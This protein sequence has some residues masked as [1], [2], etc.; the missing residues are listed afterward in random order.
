MNLRTITV[1]APVQVPP[2]GQKG[3]FLHP[4]HNG[5]TFVFK[6]VH[7]TESPAFIN[8]TTDEILRWT[9]SL[10]GGIQ[11]LPKHG[12]AVIHFRDILVTDDGEVRYLEW[13][14]SEWFPYC[15]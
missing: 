11:D 3:S 12:K 13:D 5:E 14:W 9:M 6:W 8:P 15:P 2:G 4:T 10:D 7:P 1:P